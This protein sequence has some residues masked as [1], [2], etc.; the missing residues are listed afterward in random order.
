MPDGTDNPTTFEAVNAARKKMQSILRD[1]SE[2][3]K[4]KAAGLYHAKLEELDALLDLESDLNTADAL[5]ML[6]QAE[7][8]L[9]HLKETTQKIEETVRGI[10][11]VKK[12]LKVITATID[13][14]QG[15]MLSDGELLN[16]GISDALEVLDAA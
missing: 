7:A 4:L 14:A 11:N 15:V 6:R 5:A 3:R 1:K 10:N 8:D 13:I 9:A 2:K 16:A 12:A